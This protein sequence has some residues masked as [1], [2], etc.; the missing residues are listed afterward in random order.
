MTTYTYDYELDTDDPKYAQAGNLIKITSPLTTEGTPE[1]ELTYNAHGEIT[2]VK[3]PNGNVVSYQYYPSTGYLENI[4][5]DPSGINAITN[6]TYDAYGNVDIVTDGGCRKLTALDRD[7]QYG[8]GYCRR[9]S[10]VG[11]INLICQRLH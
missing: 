2:E 6:L 9:G 3:G 5:R 1:Y 11:S 8:A 4:I 10:C 7:R